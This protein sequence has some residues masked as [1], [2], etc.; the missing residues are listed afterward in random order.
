MTPM[1]PSKEM[2]IAELI[3]EQLDAVRG[4]QRSDL[5]LS[6]LIATAR[7]VRELLRLRLDLGQRSACRETA[8]PGP[9]VK[10]AGL[11]LCAACG[12][13]LTGPYSLD[14]NGTGTCPE[15][16]GR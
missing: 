16:Q 8:D 5:P 13:E 15:C 6:D 12:R 10:V 3:A 4:K 1:T 14:G 9:S 11:P 2:S 7:E